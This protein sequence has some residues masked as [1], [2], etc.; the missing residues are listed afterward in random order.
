MTRKEY[1]EQAKAT[2]A[3]VIADYGKSAEGAMY[4]MRL[5]EFLAG[6]Y[7]P[8]YAPGDLI[9]S[10]TQYGDGCLVGCVV[11]VDAKNRMQYLIRYMRSGGETLSPWFDSNSGGV[12]DISKIDSNRK[13]GLL[14]KISPKHGLV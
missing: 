13:T 10:S 11:S 12:Y 4:G 8:K 3:D 7:V 9:V 14:G 2:M 5:D 6:T 1:Y